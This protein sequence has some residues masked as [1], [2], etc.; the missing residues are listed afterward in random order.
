[1]ASLTLSPE[2]ARSLAQVH[3]QGR[4]FLIETVAKSWAANPEGCGMDAKTIWHG[5]SGRSVRYLAWTDFS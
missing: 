4:A 2:R 1:M 3:A 5:P